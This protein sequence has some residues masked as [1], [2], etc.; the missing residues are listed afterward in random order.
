[1]KLFGLIVEGPILC[2]IEIVLRNKEVEDGVA[3]E[4]Q[5]L[6]VID[7]HIN[8]VLVLSGRVEVLLE[9]FVSHRL[10][11]ETRV[12]KVIAYHVL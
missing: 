10:D 8:V 4:L 2:D 3:Q 11:H 5:P 9:G 6:I 12:L 7:V 1:M